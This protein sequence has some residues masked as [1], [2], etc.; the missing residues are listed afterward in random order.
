MFEFLTG[1]FLWEG[2]LE[3]LQVDEIKNLKSA[4]G[5]GLPCVS[6]KANALFLSQTYRLL[7]NPSSNQFGH[8]KYWLGLHLRD[9]FPVMAG[10]PHAELVSR[11]F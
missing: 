11:Y 9:Y 1:R 4:G 8:I 3:R 7:V 6:S 10:G 5:L 2:K